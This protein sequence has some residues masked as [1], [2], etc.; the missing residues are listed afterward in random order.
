MKATAWGVS[1]L[2]V[3]LVGISRIYLGVHWPTDVAA[4]WVLGAAW[5]AAVLATI[6]ITAPAR[7]PAAGRRLMD[8][9]HGWRSRYL[10]VARYCSL[11]CS[12]LL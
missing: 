9:G 5:L 1:G 7:T 10:V 3:L 2:V 8:G 6:A 11:R 4:G 12:Q